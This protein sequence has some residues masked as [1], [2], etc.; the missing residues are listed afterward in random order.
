LTAFFP[1]Y[2][3]T[4]KQVPAVVLGIL[5]Q[6]LSWYDFLESNISNRGTLDLLFPFSDPSAVAP[7]FDDRPV[8]YW[9]KF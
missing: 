8:V 7:I 6:A 9:S 2:H 5:D 1:G 3:F 4:T